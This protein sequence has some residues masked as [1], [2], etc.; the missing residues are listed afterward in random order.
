M[1]RAMLGMLRAA[2]ETL[3]LMAALAALL[4]VLVE[5]FG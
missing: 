4:F 1:I 3:C 2:I 5:I